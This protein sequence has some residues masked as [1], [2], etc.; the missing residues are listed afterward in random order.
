MRYLKHYLT[1]F[2]QDGFMTGVLG[3]SIALSFISFQA[4]YQFYQVDYS[5]EVPATVVEVREN[6]ATNSGG[7]TNRGYTLLYA[8]E[9]EGSFYESSRYN[10]SFDTPREVLELTSGD[11]ITAL[12]NPADPS[13]A[14]IVD[15]ISWF[16]FLG[17]GLGVLLFF[18]ALVGHARL[19]PF[20]EKAAT[21][22]DL[23]ETLSPELR[24]QV[25]ERLE[26][27][28]PERRMFEAS[29][30]LTRNL[31]VDVTVARKMVRRLVG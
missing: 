29:S 18:V 12:L 11:R 6:V 4:L 23:L 8:Y 16:N 28:P 1:T 15:E 7:R 26:K 31:G 19:F 21:V 10:Y 17:A 13:D 25:L 14:V 3:L 30:L 9:Y 27:A 5:I 20:Y 2:F 24:Q 22:D